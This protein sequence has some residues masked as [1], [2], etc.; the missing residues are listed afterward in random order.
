[1]EWSE[2]GIVFFAAGDQ[3]KAIRQS[4]SYPMQLML[5][6]YEFP[7]E[8]GGD[9]PKRFAVDHGRGYRLL[10]PER[11]AIGRTPLRCETSTKSPVFLA[12]HPPEV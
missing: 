3:V 7:E 6:I 9:Y 1:V 11:W 5:S 4:P 2:D 12:S 8:R 10:K